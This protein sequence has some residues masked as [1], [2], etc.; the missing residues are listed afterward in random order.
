MC[1]CVSVRACVY[2]SESVCV[3]VQVSVCVYERAYAYVHACVMFV[4]QVED[5]STKVL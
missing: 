4:K 5:K 3:C 1:V 2:A